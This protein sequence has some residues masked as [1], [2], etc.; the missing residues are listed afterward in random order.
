MSRGPIL[1]TSARGLGAFASLRSPHM[2]RSAPRFRIGLLIL[3]TLVA[4]SRLA[5]GQGSSATR[6]RVGAR[7]DRWRPARRNRN[8][9]QHGH[10]NRAVDG[11]RRPRVVPASRASSRAPTTSRSSCPGSR[12]TSEHRWRSARTTTAASTSGSRSASRRRLVTV[13]GVAGS[14]PDG[15]GRPRRR[16]ERQADR[17]PVD[18]RPQ[19]A[20]ADAHPAGRRHRVQ[21]SANRWASAAA[22][23]TRRAT[24]STASARRATR[25]RS[26]A[27]HSSTSAATAASSCR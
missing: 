27:R 23:T 10:Q 14:H 6:S 9:D 8:G 17:Q 15:D 7:P 25:S 1:G 4:T 13:T 18:H 2:T 16:A 20:R 12:P 3:C 26:T 19:L 24:R 22:A 5:V 21:R 11:H